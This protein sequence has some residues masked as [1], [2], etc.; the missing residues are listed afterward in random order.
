M[1][2]KKRRNWIIAI[3]LL[4]LIV[5][6]MVMSGGKEERVVQAEN[7]KVRDITEKV[8]ASGKVQPSSEVKIQSDVS[9]QIVE[10]PVKEGD[11]VEKGQLLVKINPDLYTSALQR[12]EATLNSARSNLASAR[13]RLAQAQAQA[14]AQELSFKRNEKLFT[15]RAISAAEMDNARSTYETS[16]A[17]VVAATESIHSAEFSIASAEASRNEASD[18]LKRTT[19]VAPISGTVTA[20]TKEV[21]E[22]VL[23]NNMTS[24]DVIMK[25]SGLSAMEVNVEV[26]ESDIVRVHLGDTAEIE[27]DAFRNEKFL[28]VVTE[29]GNTALNLMSGSNLS[30][31]ANNQVTNFSVKISILPGSYS[32]IQSGKDSPFRPGMTATVN[33][34]T[35][36]SKG[37]LSIPIKSVT[38]RPDT[39]N[40]S[41]S[42]TC[43]FV[44][45][46][47]SH[48]ARLRFVKTGIQDDQFI[49][50]LEGIQLEEQVITGPYDEIAKSLSNGDQVTKGELEKVNKPS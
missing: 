17:E 8:S 50:V 45:D 36:R 46:E 29:I 25:I 31:T 35:K 3:S 30:A 20:L 14:K 19:I 9:G 49:H 12:S 39:V 7:P 44:Y 32:H 15:E 10:L 16:Q 43:V 1:K 11:H 22:A 6:I 23:G 2:N 41:E 24:G 5:I 21:G 4:A 38:M 37:V 42:K 28:G 47:A 40:T 26:N 27:V 18:N 34:L 33:V 13:A 48:Q